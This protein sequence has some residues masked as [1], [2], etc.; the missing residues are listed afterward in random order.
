RAALARTLQRLLDAIHA[1]HLPAAA[2]QPHRPHGAAGAYVQ[3][4]PVGGLAPRLLLGEQPS[5]LFDEGGLVGSVL[6]GMKA[7]AVCEAVVHRAH[8]TRSCGGYAVMCL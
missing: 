2:R 3:R 7:D 4:A 1:A 5:E 8:P 6:P